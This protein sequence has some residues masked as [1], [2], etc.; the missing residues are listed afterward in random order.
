MRLT[1]A[2]LRKLK[3]RDKAY[4]ETDGLGL[5]V[6]VPPKGRPRW[7]FD[8]RYKG[9]RKTL[10]MGVYPDISLKAA[11]EKRDAAREQVAQGLDPSMVRVSERRKDAE[12]YANNF[13]SIAREW[14]KKF[15]SGWAESHSKRV[16]RRLE[17][18]VFPRLGSMPITDI[19]PP[20]LLGALRKIEER[21]AIETAHRVK[22]TCGQIYRYGVA[23][24]YCER[25]IT[26][27]LRGA[28]PPPNTRHHPSI[29]EPREIGALLRAIDS[30]DGSPLTRLAL[31]LAPLVF[32][33]PGELRGARWSEL[34]LHAAEWRI[35]EDRMKMDEPHIVPLAR[36][37]VELFLELRD[38]TG[39]YDLVFP[40][41]RSKHRPMSDNTLNGALRRLGYATDEMTA[42]GFRSMASTR[43]NESGKWN[44]DSI[45]RQLAHAE[46]DSVRA[47]Y[48]YAQ[49]L[50]ER[51]KMMQWWAD[52]LDE[53]RAGA[54]VTKLRLVGG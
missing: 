30:Y 7:R 46:R 35:P 18:N 36:Q 17:A 24:G 44:R 8:Y 22:Q 47:A 20:V 31:Q 27:D 13:E 42:H 4:K 9:K 3:P 50:P 52:Y 23:N 38:H 10:S 29:T 32:V 43:L 5:Y 51:T 49:H 21:G 1:D 26:Q 12:S 25:D 11:R 34:D 6:I 37:A 16:M 41:V 15:S 40:G 28:L 48:N 2:K 19:E 54:A 39:R 33:R 45:E 14:F 53:L